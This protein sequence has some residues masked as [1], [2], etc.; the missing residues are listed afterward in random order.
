ME[1][2]KSPF[3]IAAETTPE[4]S[5]LQVAEKAVQ[6]TLIAKNTESLAAECEE[7]ANPEE[8]SA[9]FEETEPDTADQVSAAKEIPVF[10]EMPVLEEVPITT[11]AEPPLPPESTPEE[12]SPVVL[13]PV[14]AKK[15]KKP[16][17]ICLGAAAAVILSLTLLFVL[18]KPSRTIKRAQELSLLGDYGEALALLDDLSS[19]KARL[20]EKEIYSLAEGDLEAHLDDAD[21]EKARKLLNTLPDTPESEDLWGKVFESVEEG[22]SAHL[23]DGDYTAA[24]ELLDENNDLPNAALVQEKVWSLKSASIEA[25]IT[26]LMDDGDYIAAQE[27]LDEN[28]DLPNAALLQ[29]QIM[30]ESF[31]LNCAFDL[32]PHM[33]NPSSL[34]FNWVEFYASPSADDYPYMVYYFSGQNGW[35]G[36]SASYG[37][38]DNDDMT[39]LGS[40][41][42]LDTYDIDDVYEYMTALIIKGYR[43]KEELPVSFNLNRINTI[44]ATGNFPKIDITRYTQSNSE[45]NV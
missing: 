36:A 39:H 29:E 5:D 35:G 10:E 11:V 7:I 37:T 25:D 24:Q 14:A 19:N 26:A 44:L 30:Y 13:T 20:A 38:A 40:T 22:I 8:A 6:T 3:E 9:C 28:N 41:D 32:R 2:K 43:E 16:L 1:N 17:L 31:I 18:S 23:A 15:S 21:Y 4:N 45:S 42:T 33:K 27:L 12:I 34:Q